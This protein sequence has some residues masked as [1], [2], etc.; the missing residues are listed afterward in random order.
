MGM[1]FRKQMTPGM[2]KCKKKY[3]KDSPYKAADASLIAGQK[4]LSENAMDAVAGGKTGTEK[5][6][7]IAQQQVDKYA[8]K[9]EVNFED[10]GYDSDEQIQKN[11]SV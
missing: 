2:E 6:A 10:Y 9:D 3:G 7:D 5:A 11:L 4:Q 8:G 1:N